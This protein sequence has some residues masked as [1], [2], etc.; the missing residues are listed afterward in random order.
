MNAQ[1]DLEIKKKMHSRLP[2]DLIRKCKI[3][4][5]ADQAQDSGRYLQPS[6]EKKNKEVKIKWD[7]QEV[8]DLRTLMYPVLSFTCRWVDVQHQKLK[9]Q[10]I[11]MTFS[12]E[13]QG[14]GE[15]SANENTSHS[16]GSKRKEEPK[17]R[18]SSKK[19]QKVNPDHPP[20]ASSRH[21]KEIGQNEDQREKVHEID[22]SMESTM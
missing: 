16:K 8:T 6:Y 19:K 18:E 22:E 21:E 4:R 15:A 2:L 13:T 14:E 3:Y 10:N 9:E 17:K 11:A 12:L 1:D 5:V 20:N 7:E